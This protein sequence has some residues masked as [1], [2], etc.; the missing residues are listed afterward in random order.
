MHGANIDTLS[1]A[2]QCKLLFLAV[3]IERTLR[4][5]LSFLNDYSRQYLE[6]D[7]NGC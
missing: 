4:G 6:Q 3:C 5:V 2:E 7:G 1:F